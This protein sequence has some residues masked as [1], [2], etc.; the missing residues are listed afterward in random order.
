VILAGLKLTLCNERMVTKLDALWL[1]YAKKLAIHYYSVK[2]YRLNCTLAMSIACYEVNP[3]QLV[4][5]EAVVYIVQCHRGLLSM[6]ES[7]PTF[8]H[9]CPV[10]P[11]NCR[12][13]PSPARHHAPRGTRTASNCHVTSRSSYRKWRHRTAAATTATCATAPE[14]LTARTSSTLTVS[15]AASAADIESVTSDES[16]VV[17]PRRELCHQP[18]LCVILSV[19][20]SV[21]PHDKTKTGLKLY[22]HQT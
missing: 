3:E 12:A 5:S 21:C 13:A 2:I 8:S 7:C 19:C 20:L 10:P 9:R 16:T 1:L 4:S 6:S 11:S 18:R 17:S 14:T 15:S 22:D